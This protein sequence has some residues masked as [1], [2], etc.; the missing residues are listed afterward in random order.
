MSEVTAS[1]SIAD[2]DAGWCFDTDAGRAVWL[3]EHAEVIA[4]AMRMAGLA[5][6][7]KALSEERKMPDRVDTVEDMQE[8]PREALVSAV[9]SVLRS[10]W[11]VP[12]SLLTWHDTASNT[13][14]LSFTLREEAWTLMPRTQARGL[15]TLKARLYSAVA[16]V[17]QVPFEV[18]ALSVDIDGAGPVRVRLYDE[19]EE[20]VA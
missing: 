17:L 2:I 4:L 8:A 7:E 10:T 19:T 12:D 15:E 3:R 11:I 9:Y 6:M 14:V 20:E 13:E 1:V 16:A 18:Y 5:A